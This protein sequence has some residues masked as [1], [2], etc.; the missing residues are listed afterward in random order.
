MKAIN[1]AVMEVPAV[2]YGSVISLLLH[3]NSK[4]EILNLKCPS[5]A[6]YQCVNGGRRHLIIL[7]SAVMPFRIIIHTDEE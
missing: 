5:Y 4:Y 3:L 2:R 6:G 1:F 7:R